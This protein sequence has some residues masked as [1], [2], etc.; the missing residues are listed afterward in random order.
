MTER[1][2]YID[3]RILTNIYEELEKQGI[4]QDEFYNILEE[5]TPF[6]ES[7]IKNILDR[8]NKRPI[9]LKELTYFSNLLGLDNPGYLLKDIS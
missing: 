6:K 7:R 8:T 5:N 9:T 1:E 4:S 2:K 3:D